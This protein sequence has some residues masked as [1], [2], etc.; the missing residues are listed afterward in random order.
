MKL[1]YYW[2]FATRPQSFLSPRECA[3]SV[4]RL[5]RLRSWEFT[6]KD[7]REIVVRHAMPED[8]RHMHDGFCA[9]V[10]EGK[11]L[12]TLTPNGT[13]SDWIS[14][15]HRTRTSRNVLLVA[16]IDEQYV[17]H[18]SLQPEEWDASQHVASLGLIVMKGY[19]G[20]GVGRSLM[21]VAE[22][23]AIE[24]EFEKI[25]LSTFSSNEKARRLYESLGYEL[26]G[27]RRRHFKMFG[28][29]VDEALY[30]KHLNPEMGSH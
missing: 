21:H 16:E 7:G 6:S 11:W 3:Y 5:R 18:L 25:I 17:G 28:A 27:I 24:N 2:T 14:W 23:V 29:Y 10:E 8:A 13:I 1:A 22:E 20:I 30:E 19:R 15:I 26:V 4:L 12:P 9:V